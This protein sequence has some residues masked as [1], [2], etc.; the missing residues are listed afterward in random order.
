MK[1][2]YI[3]TKLKSLPKHCGVCPYYAEWIDDEPMWGDGVHHDCSL[4]SGDTSGC[5]VERPKW[6]PL[7]LGT[8]TPY[9]RQ[10]ESPIE[11]PLCPECNKQMVI[12]VNSHTT[13]KFWGCPD[14][15]KCKGRL[16]LDKETLPFPK[17]G[18]S[19]G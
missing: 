19:R 1:A 11:I 5:V 12:R 7:T 2:I 14:F 15:P 18:K 4:A 10:K 3:A 6:C 17:G 16:D 13:N 8:V 9:K